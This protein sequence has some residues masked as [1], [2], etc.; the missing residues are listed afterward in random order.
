[1]IGAAKLFSD[2]LEHTRPLP[3]VGIT[4]GAGKFCE[5]FQIPPNLRHHIVD[6]GVCIV[7]RKQAKIKFKI[8]LSKVDY[9]QQ[10]IKQALAVR[11]INMKI[12]GDAGPK[13]YSIG[14]EW[15][16]V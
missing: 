9:G 1:M 6:G 11:K 14:R 10:V 12:L 3:I 16:R 13:H 8:P 5:Y 7:K 15:S 2:S 4:L